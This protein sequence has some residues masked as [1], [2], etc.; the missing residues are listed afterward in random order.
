MCQ[1]FSHFQL[2][3]HHFVLEKS[4]TSRLRVNMIRLFFMHQGAV[5]LLLLQSDAGDRCGKTRI[6]FATG[7][8][9]DGERGY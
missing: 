4:A 6:H 2:F 3:M 5:S 1:C 9:E 7:T 8:D